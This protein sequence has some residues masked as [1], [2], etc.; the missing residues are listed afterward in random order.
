MASTT[1]LVAAIPEI[2][3]QIQ[4]DNN[5]V[6]QTLDL[7]PSPADA[8]ASEAPHSDPPSE[9]TALLGHGAVR[10]GS[11]E[12]RRYSTKRQREESAQRRRSLPGWKRAMPVWMLLPFGL[13]K[14]LEAGTLS[15][16]MELLTQISCRGV[17]VEHETPPVLQPPFLPPSQGDYAPTSLARTAEIAESFIASAP[18]APPRTTF[19]GFPLARAPDEE[20]MHRCRRS[21]E[22]QKRT[23]SFL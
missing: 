4:P 16:Q 2:H 9:H 11:L 13:F 1:S 20:W 3:P 15:V 7:H 8:C 22:V 14:L 18:P 12:T 19:M 17:V 10:S 23:T 21:G 6:D 5:L